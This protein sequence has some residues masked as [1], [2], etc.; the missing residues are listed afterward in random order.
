M[1]SDGP[2]RWVLVRPLHLST[3]YD[4]E[5]QEPLGLEY[6]AAVLRE[7]G[8]EVL[9]LDGALSGGDEVRLAR[10]AASFEP[11]VIGLSLTTAAQ[12]PAARRFHGECAAARADPIWLAGGN[13]VST[14]PSQAVRLLP[15]GVTLVRFE[16]EGVARR[17]SRLVAQGARPE[18]DVLEGEPVADLDSLPFA[19]RDFA[20]AVAAAGWAFNMQGSRGCCGSCRYCGSSSVWGRAGRTWRGRSPA[21]VAAEMELLVR[22]YGVRSFNFVDE[23]FLGP[24]AGAEE[25]AAELARQILDRRLDV[26]FGVQARPSTLGR[27]AVRHLARAGLAYAFL[28]IE[29][30]DPEDFARWGRPWSGAPWGTVARLREHGVEVGA[31]VLLFHRHSTLEGIRRFSAALALHGLLNYRT[32]INRLDA[33]PGSLLR[34]R[35][36]ERGDVSPGHCGPATMAFQRPEVARLYNDLRR[37]ADPLGPPSMHAVCALPPLLGAARHEASARPRLEALRQIITTGDRAVVTTVSALL[38]HPTEPDRGRVESL[39]LSNMELAHDLARR[40][41]EAQFAPSLE[42]LRRAIEVDAGS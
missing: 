19:H 24:E 21:H 7:E 16:A 35:A 8:D 1:S 22:R 13:F 18:G 30:D 3:Y 38:D 36:E 32:A 4:P 17:V 20:G 15:E 26:S 34:R 33:M 2:A 6:L 29:S 28:G 14:E 23:D 27:R 10:R 12:V 39:R 31:G 25:R 11:D 37:A 41:V 40:L 5:L 42:Q 9:L